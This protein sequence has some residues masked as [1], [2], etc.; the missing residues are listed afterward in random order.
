MRTA[1]AIEVPNALRMWAVDVAACGGAVVLFGS[2]ADLKERPN[3]D[4]DVAVVGDP[5]LA[6][7]AP[8]TPMGMDVQLV[9]VTLADLADRGHVYPGIAYEITRHGVLL[10]GENGL[11]AIMGEGKQD[12]GEKKVVVDA[13]KRSDEFGRFIGGAIDYAWDF[14]RQTDEFQFWDKFGDEWDYGEESAYAILPERSADTAEFVTKAICLATGNDYARIHDLEKLALSVPEQLRDRVR[15]LNGHTHDDHMAGYSPAP[16]SPREVYGRVVNAMNLL[17]DMA[18]WDVPLLSDRARSLTIRLDGL[19]Q[20]V[21]KH[22][23]SR[24]E[25]PL[26]RA[27]ANALV[28]WQARTREVERETDHPSPPSEQAPRAGARGRRG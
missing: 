7:R 25:E 15:G 16:S 10:A 27:F 1:A 22:G 14:I 23:E 9:H 11:E 6:G 19:A 3:S 20:R 18:K 13:K 26:V 2:R 28:A 5:T 4:W 17:A 8:P 12:K 24:P 21:A